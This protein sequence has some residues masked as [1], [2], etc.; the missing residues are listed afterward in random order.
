MSRGDREMVMWRRAEVVRL[1]GAGWSAHQIG[2]LL[3]ITDRSVLRHRVAAG[4]AQP[5]VP[6]VTVEELARAD[7]LLADGCSYAEVARTLGRSTSPFRR[8][9]PG[10]GWTTEQAIELLMAIKKCDGTKL[11][12]RMM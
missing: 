3:G 11:V 4:V 8:S 10:R 7:A 6:P 2:Q 1:T 12:G 9:F 5:P